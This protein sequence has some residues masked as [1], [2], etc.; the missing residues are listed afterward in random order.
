[1]QKAL[2]LAPGWTWAYNTLCYI[3]FKDGNY[4][5]EKETAYDA[6]HKGILDPGIL[7]N[8]KNYTQDDH[9]IDES[10]LMGK[11]T[12][13]LMDSR[14]EYDDLLSYRAN[15]YWG[16]GYPDKA[17]KTFK[18]Y[19]KQV[20][21]G[22]DNKEKS[23]LWFPYHQLGW[24]LTVKG[25]WDEAE[26][27]YKMSDSIKE[28]S[29]AKA[30][31]FQIA[32]KKGQHKLAKKYLKSAIKTGYYKNPQT[33][34]YDGAFLLC[35]YDWVD[36]V[37]LLYSSSLELFPKFAPLRYDLGRIYLEQKNDYRKGISLLKKAVKL[38]STHAYARYHL[39]AAYAHIGK[40][41]AAL[42]HLDKALEAGFDEFEQLAGDSRWSALCDTQGYKA[43]IA[44]YKR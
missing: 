31:L 22:D 36:E 21:A 33:I 20:L 2:D 19:I 42:K 9:Q 39:A 11:K 27:W 23:K 14:D 44:K 41:E 38:D 7:N 30:G 3:Y 10:K 16:S 1:M 5:K 26:R 17:E 28:N 25:E 24:V 43:L 12:I 8:L 32:H 35:I 18:K 29:L 15:Q 4:R 34:V 13:E 40:N 37:I 6:Y